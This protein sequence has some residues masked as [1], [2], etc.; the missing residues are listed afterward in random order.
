VGV[1]P[2]ITIEV[3]A[4]QGPTVLSN[5]AT[6]S[7]DEDDTVPGDDAATEGTTVL[8]APQA[9]LGIDKSDGGV[10]AVRGEPLTYTITV[11]NSGPDAAPGATVADAFPADLE[12][13]TWGCVASAG[14]SCA[15]SGS[16]DISDSA[17]LLAGGTL[18][19]SATGTVAVG[20]TD[21][22]TN[23]ATV[24]APP[25]V[26]DP[27]AGNDSAT[28]VT[29]VTDPVDV[30]F[31]DGFESGD[32]SAWSNT[33]GG[34]FPEPVLHVPDEMPERDSIYRGRVS[35]DPGTLDSKAKPIG[36]S[37][38]PDEGGRPIIG[39][40]LEPVAEEYVL[41]ARARPDVRTKAAE[42]SADPHDI[43]FEWI[44]GSTRSEAGSLRIWVDGT[45]VGES[46]E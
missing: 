27:N 19:Y 16:G 12:S 15:P 14:S 28:V 7:A 11:T 3:R 29:E 40:T 33:V 38:T 18:T 42:I 30:I 39:F 9:D 6:V 31:E 46:A 8:A 20:A 43:R 22:M 45:L 17:S 32:T 37:V 13:V 21:P 10:T 1:A 5:T 35:F 23:T 25:S 34:A 24:T 2:D 44:L 26:L 36:F 41:A 4:P